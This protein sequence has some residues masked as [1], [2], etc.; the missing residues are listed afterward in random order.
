MLTSLQDATEATCQARLQ[1]YF[2]DSYQTMM[3]G[4]V[5]F[6]KYVPTTIKSSS[7]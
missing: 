3:Q 7:W 4:R 1:L 6:I 2:P 5:R